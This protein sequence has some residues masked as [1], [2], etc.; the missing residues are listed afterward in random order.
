MRC[1]QNFL[2]VHPANCQPESISVTTIST[3]NQKSWGAIPGERLQQLL[4]RPFRSGMS[5][6]VEM[7]DSSAMMLQHNKHEQEP[8]TQSRYHEEI[9][10][11]E[12]LGMM[13]QEC[14]PG[15]RRWLAMP[16]HVL[17][18]SGFGQLDPEFQ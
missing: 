1:R 17:G 2:N 3:S 5:R 12:L 9:N 11:D 16:N 14:P 10:R 7:H 18:D 15:L 4:R 13:F 6:N 8:E